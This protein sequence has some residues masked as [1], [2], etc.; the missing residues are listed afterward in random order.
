MTTHLSLVSNCQPDAVTA[1]REAH[2]KRAAWLDSLAPDR[3]RYRGSAGTE[4]MKKLRPLA[5]D[6]QACK[7]RCEEKV[8]AAKADD[9]S[10]RDLLKVIS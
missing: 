7:E 9:P 2:E 5:H 4:A 1:A 6:E 10:W 3:S 8:R